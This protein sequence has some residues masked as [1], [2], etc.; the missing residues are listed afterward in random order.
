MMMKMK[1]QN[2]A[3]KIIIATSMFLLVYLSQDTGGD[4]TSAAEHPRSLRRSSIYVIQNKAEA[5]RAKTD[6]S[7]DLTL[8]EDLDASLFKRLLQMSM[9]IDLDRGMGGGSSAAEPPR[10]LR[11]SSYYSIQNQNK[12]KP[13][14]KPKRVGPD[15]VLDLTLEEDLVDAVSWCKDVDT[16]IDTITSMG[17]DRD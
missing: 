3:L 9:F 10:Y 14:T 5:K 7:S 15:Y 11:R 4:D 16:Y 12:E 13:K 6:Y 17:I 1:M 2:V 8:E